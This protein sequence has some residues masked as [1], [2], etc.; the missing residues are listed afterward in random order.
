MKKKNHEKLQDKGLTAEFLEQHHK[1]AI[2]SLS[3]SEHAELEKLLKKVHD[4]LPDEHK[5][6][7]AFVV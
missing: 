6:H 1:D 5:A 2:D 4:A 3:E 7:P